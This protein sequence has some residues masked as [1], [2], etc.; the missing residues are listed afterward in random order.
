MR[1]FTVFIP[2]IVNI[3]IFPF[4]N[5]KSFLVWNAAMLAVLH[6][7]E[8]MHTVISKIIC[9]NQNCVW[10]QR[11]RILNQGTQ[12]SILYKQRESQILKDTLYN[13]HS[14]RPDT[15]CARRNSKRHTGTGHHNTAGHS[16]LYH[17]S[18][19]TYRKRFLI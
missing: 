6:D 19:E 11:L 10:P 9:K 12:S 15:S 14:I 7:T 13:P 17:I 5:T 18:N 3:Q 16:K 4:R 2:F 1:L 8:F